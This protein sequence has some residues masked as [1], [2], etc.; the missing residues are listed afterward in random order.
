MRT[1][2]VRVTT[3]LAVHDDGVMMSARVEATQSRVLGLFAEE[4]EEQGGQGWEAGADDAKA[5]FDAGPEGG[6]CEG[7]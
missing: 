7:I 3:E 2:R 6:V 1:Y 5:D 4:C